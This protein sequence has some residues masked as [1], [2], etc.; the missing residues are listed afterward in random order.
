MLNAALY[1]SFIFTCLSGGYDGQNNLTCVEMYDPALDEWVLAPPMVAHEGGVGVGVIPKAF[2]CKDAFKSA[3]SLIS[4][5]SFSSLRT[6][7]KYS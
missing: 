5:S 1:F 6:K 4:Q 3:K 7:A 2:D